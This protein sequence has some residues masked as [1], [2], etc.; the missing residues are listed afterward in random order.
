MTT[1][2]IEG[3]LDLLELLGETDPPEGTPAAG[4]PGAVV[5]FHVRIGVVRED[6]TRYLTTANRCGLCGSKVLSSVGAGSYGGT[7]E[8]GDHWMLQHC[9]RCEER[10]IRYRSI[11]RL[12]RDGVFQLRVHDDPGDCDTCDRL[13][14]GGGVSCGEH[15]RGPIYDRHVCAVCGRRFRGNT[16]SKTGH[17]VLGY[18]PVSAPYCSEAC[19]SPAAQLTRDLYSELTATPQED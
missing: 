4:G 1:D 14:A 15:Q 8:N 7:Q 19:F 13:A 17:G 2:V 12:V 9:G 11:E 18:G 10:H 6:G 3:Q 5:L 16:G